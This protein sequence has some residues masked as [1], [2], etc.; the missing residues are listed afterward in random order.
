ML[1][2][3]LLVCCA[4]SIAL[5]LFAGPSAALET[6]PEV[7]IT[8]FAGSGAAGF[9]DGLPGSFLMPFGLAYGPDGTLYVTD[10]GAQR[11]RAVDPQGRVRTIAGSGSA[12]ATGLWVRGG[13][14]DGSPHEAQFDRPA[15]I[16]WVD[17][18]LYVADTNN[19]CIRRVDA[20]GTV[21]TFAG[22][23]TRPGIADGPLETASFA[24]P[25]GLA[26]DRAGHIYV[27]DFFGIR[28]IHDGRVTTFPNLASTPFGVSE[29]D[30]PAGPVL[31]V[32]DDL[33][34]VRRM[35]DGSTERYAVEAALTK[36]TRNIQ[37]EEP[38]GQPFSLAA[39]DSSS[40]IYGDV[41]GNS[42]RYLNWEAGS[43]QIL[44]GLD[45][46]DGDAT[47]A[48]WHDGSGGETRFDG[49]TGFAIAP[50]GTVAIADSGSRRIRLLKNLDRRHDA[51]PADALPAA[52]ADPHAYR[53]A[54]IG[55]SFLW[56]Y[57]RWSTSIPGI[58]ESRLNQVAKPS[59]QGRKFVVTPYIFP[60][61]PIVAMAGYA[62]VVLG[63]THAADLVVLN[64]ATSNLY[65]MP[66]IPSSA[67]SAQII[68]AEPSWTKQLT[69]SLR[70]ADAALRKDGITLV[71][72]TTPLPENLSPVES[73][74][75][76]LLAADGQ[77]SASFQIGAAMNRAVQQSGVAFLDGWSIFEAESR[78]PKHA[79]LFGTQDIHFSPHGR[80]VLAD[81]LATYLERTRPW[82]R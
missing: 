64:V 21:H 4:A 47:S 29:V 55:N 56:S 39:F 48:G 31:F 76:R 75:N 7:A 79:A 68:A 26:K 42:I 59:A 33:G 24:R 13:Y 16:V 67:T 77:T 12:D 23:P 27:A 32:A 6:S 41:R 71:V 2:F 22:S 72:V 65:G 17:G 66:D 57:D 10:A 34:L 1:K 15:G 53:I 18:K 60:G 36:T 62:N 14:R 38:L 5:A 63:E 73:L 54:F 74:W 46:Y 43:E 9:A 70:E 52:V 25:T 49:P 78:S 69:D 37:G 40:V 35:P 50:N 11:I 8:T 82:Q 20:D 45:T 58:V 51:H 81:A 3:R 80:A 44:G 61:S 30:S 19:H 28:E